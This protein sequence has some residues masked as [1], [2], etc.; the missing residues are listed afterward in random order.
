MLAIKYR[1][2][3][4]TINLN[5]FSSFLTNYRDSSSCF[6]LICFGVLDEERCKIKELN[7]RQ[8]DACTFLSSFQ[9]YQT[10][11]VKLTPKEEKNKLF[12]GA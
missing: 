6:P 7:L 11:L 3:L 1:L 4:C 12:E 10:F 2:P 9:H 5:A 8:F